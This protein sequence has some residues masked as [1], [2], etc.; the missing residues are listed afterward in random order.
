MATNYVKS[1]FARG[2]DDITLVHTSI[3]I[4]TLNY[5]LSDNSCHGEFE[6][7]DILSFDPSVAYFVAPNNRHVIMELSR[8]LGEPVNIFYQILTTVRSLE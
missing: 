6:S 4:I 5:Y 8:P 7:K 1:W 2:D 3:E